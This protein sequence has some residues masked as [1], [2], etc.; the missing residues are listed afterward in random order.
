[1]MVDSLV[2]TT[3]PLLECTAHLFTQVMPLRA[4]GSDAPDDLYEQVLNCLLYTSPSPR[5]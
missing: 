4:G 2:A 3:N 5:D 1:M